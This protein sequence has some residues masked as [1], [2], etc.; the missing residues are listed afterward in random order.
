MSWAPDGLNEW[1]AQGRA[2]CVPTRPSLGSWH[3][4]STEQER[5]AQNY[6]PQFGENCR[7]ALQYPHQNC[8]RKAKSASIYHPVET[9]EWAH[10]LGAGHQGNGEAMNFQ[11]VPKYDC[12]WIHHQNPDSAEW[13][14]G[15]RLYL[16]WCALSHGG[17]DREARV[18]V[19]SRIRK[20]LFTGSLY[21]EEIKAGC[22]GPE[23]LSFLPKSKPDSPHLYIDAWSIHKY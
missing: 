10:S 20:A 1:G 16:L 4:L 17:W 8:Y 9:G 14:S 5:E 23:L 21:G 11:N 22:R 18:A 2:A 6:P 3:L 15:S 12:G 13:S 7:E 19:E